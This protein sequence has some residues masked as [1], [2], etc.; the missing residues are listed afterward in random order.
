MKSESICLLPE[1]LLQQPSNPIASKYTSNLWSPC[2]GFYLNP[3]GANCYVID[4]GIAEIS[5][6]PPVA[7]IRC[8]RVWRHW[9]QRLQHM[10]DIFDAGFLLPSVC[11]CCRTSGSILWSRPEESTG[12]T[13]VTS[14]QNYQIEWICFHHLYVPALSIQIF[15]K[16]NI[17]RYNAIAQTISMLKFMSLSITNQPLQ[18]LL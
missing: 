15:F 4:N 9:T 16:Q 13:F 17:H 12:I 1:I 3:H 8:R 6:F 7:I 10:L 2:S 18:I 5:V 14:T 11:R